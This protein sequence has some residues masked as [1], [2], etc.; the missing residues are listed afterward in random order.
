MLLSTIAIVV[1][2]IAAMIL[3]SHKIRLS[4]Q[5]RA[6][7]TPL[8]SIIGSGFLIVA[9][10]LHSVMGKWALLGMVIL[11]IFAYSLGGIIRFNIRYAEEYISSHEQS[12]IAKLEVI[13]QW[14][15]GGAYAISVAF[16]ISL[17][18]AFIFDQIGVTDTTTI[19]LATT[20][21]LLAIMT[22][23]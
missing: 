22:I 18:S 17:F 11:S 16:Y 19:K 20:L 3:F 14:F 4:S 6:T 12:K 23:A 7:V 13:G 8:A 1:S 15:L 5:W 10:L 2:T 9:P 21:M